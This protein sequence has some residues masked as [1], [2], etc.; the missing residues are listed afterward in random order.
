M[1]LRTRVDRMAGT[2]GQP[3]HWEIW[4]SDA[5]ACTNETEY[6]GQTFTEAQVDALPLPRGWGR[7]L[8]VYVDVDPSE[9]LEADDA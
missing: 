3:R 7:I 1:N 2:Q 9:A 5:G 6:P 8:V 4:Y